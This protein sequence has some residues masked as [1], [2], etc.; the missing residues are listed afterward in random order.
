MIGRP[1]SFAFL[2]LLAGAASA[3]TSAPKTPCAALD[4]TQREK[5]IHY[6]QAKYK[7]PITTPLAVSDAQVNDSCYR[8]LDL[9]SQDSH[10]PFH[11]T[12]YASPDLRFLSRDLLD[13]TVDP[14]IEERRL[15]EEMASTLAHAAKA[16]V[17]GEKEAPVTITVFSDFQCPFCA[18]AA[19]NLVGEVVPSHRGELRL[20]YCYLPLAMHPW[21]R[22]A[23]EA[24]ACARV[25]GDPYFWS[26]HDYIFEH[27]KELNPDN[28]RQNLLE[29]A[30]G[31]N[32]LDS[33][34]LAACIDQKSGAPAVDS[35]MHLARKLGISATP[36]LFINGE[37][38]GGYRPDQ[39]RSAVDRAL[40]NKPA[41]ADPP[42]H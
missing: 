2:A 13:S 20:E 17:L 32:G 22:P 40:Q 12:L 23:A 9:Q 30:A 27:Q 36:T 41:A 21:A 1:A 24:A 11:L 19:K 7:V 33:Q 37:R 29:Y 6:I 42:R 4:D 15:R 10:R 31:L 18:Q 38:V 34:A 35:D 3:Q 39:I 8:K 25:Q 28:L 5:L 26:L 16:P 14:A